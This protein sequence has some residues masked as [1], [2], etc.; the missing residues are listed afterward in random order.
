MNIPVEAQIRAIIQ[1]GSVFYFVKKTFSSR[2]P[3]YF[4]VLNQ[5]PAIDEL[6]LL[7]CSSSGIEQ[8][9]ERIR[10]RHWPESTLVEIKKEQYDDFTEETS[11]I[12]CNYV[13]TKTIEQIIEKRKK[14]ELE[15]KK[16]MDI[17]LVEKLRKGVWDSPKVKEELKQKYLPPVD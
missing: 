15:F 5:T 6:I 9:K 17:A 10:R 7:V 4:I 3:H 8:V 12:N 16:V 1:P 14:N 11:I 13:I 2:E